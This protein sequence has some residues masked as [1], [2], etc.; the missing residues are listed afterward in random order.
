VIR[1]AVLA[2]FLFALSAGVAAA[3]GDE[4]GGGGD[5]EVRVAGHCGRGATSSLRVRGRDDGIEVRFR[6][7]ETRGRGLWRITIVHENRVASRATKRTTR[8]EDSFELR[9]MLPDLPGSDAVAVHAWG[10]RGIGCRAS[11]TLPSGA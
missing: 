5:G 2:L 11:A 9:R 1:V 10:P 7:R 3:R 4:H 8:S 6:L